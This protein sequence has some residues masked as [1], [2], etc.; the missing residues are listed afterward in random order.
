M[1]NRSAYQAYADTSPLCRSM[2]H[3]KV[4]HGVNSVTFA[5]RAFPTCMRHS[6]S[7]NPESVAN[8]PPKIQI[9]DTQNLCN[10]HVPIGLTTKNLRLGI[11][12]FQPLGDIAHLSSPILITAHELFAVNLHGF[13]DQSLNVA[14]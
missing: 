8:E 5:N 10:L 13:C 4:F 14:T 12:M 9:V 6:R 7:S 1:R 2:M 11:Y 3:P